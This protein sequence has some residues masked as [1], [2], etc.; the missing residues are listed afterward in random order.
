MSTVEALAPTPARAAE[1]ARPRQGAFLIPLPNLPTPPQTGASRDTDTPTFR[2][3]LARGANDMAS[4]TRSRDSS[5]FRATEA[6]S[7]RN[8]R[9]TDRTDESKRRSRK[10]DAS[11]T[12][13]AP[14]SAAAEPEVTA[15]PSD[16]K[17]A[18]EP[19][20]TQAPAAEADDRTEATSPEAKPTDEASETS[21][22]A[23]APKPKDDGTSRPT[24]TDVPGTASSATTAKT[25]EAGAAAQAL[26]ELLTPLKSDSQVTPQSAAS[27]PSQTVQ[28]VAA[29]VATT[30]PTGE[31]ASAVES[32]EPTADATASRAPARVAPV[33][34]PAAEKASDGRTRS[35]EAGPSPMLKPGTKPA[36]ADNAA[37]AAL[38]I[39]TRP[40]SDASR[41]STQ[42]LARLIALAAGLADGG[43]TASKP[44]GTSATQRLTTSGSESSGT[45]ATATLALR[46]GPG[47]TSNVARGETF[48][49]VLNRQSAGSTSA[50]SN[51]NRVAE[52][53]RANIGTNHSSITL[54]LDPPELGAVRLEATLRHQMLS[55]RAQT[56]TQ[57][58]RDAMQSHL[59]DLRDA[60][61]RHGIT[62]E[63]FDIE[64]RPASQ[65]SNSQH[66][67]GRDA[68]SQ[69]GDQTG[70]QGGHAFQP[71]EDNASA[72][73]S[74]D[75]GYA[76]TT[77]T[78]LP[79]D[80][81]TGPAPVT[82]AAQV[83]ST[84]SETSVNV[85]V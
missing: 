25:S 68:N 81:V 60:L 73:H 51:V 63:R 39:E 78:E 14:A 37:A 1:T 30:R 57:A 36:H 32:A 46:G 24:A 16:S 8:D 80:P 64:A 76:M 62:I 54:Q 6:A 27:T 44:T 41:S 7:T 65:T 35:G 23:D 12:D 29:A 49:A 20:E 13:A 72:R 15:E 9:R 53:V 4:R 69:A 38:T 31:I 26:L 34:E 18:A 71:G 17:S 83:L 33:A 47:A 75:R 52:V 74:N 45:G 40:A 84:T 11:E 22:S 58:A 70:G 59:S 85:L 61:Q 67:T 56:E 43:G 48:S 5:S 21:S 3:L 82:A 10:A 79:E 2:S 19:D 66:N 50:A 55:I 42:D 77:E 28:T